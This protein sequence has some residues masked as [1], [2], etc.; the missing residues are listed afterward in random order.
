MKTAEAIF[1]NSKELDA[2]IILSEKNRLYYTG[3]HSTFGILLFLKNGETHFY[4]D[5]RYMEMAEQHFAGNAQVQLHLFGANASNYKTIYE[6]L[7]DNNVSKLGFEDSEMTVYDFNA[8]KL[9]FKD[10]KFV[11]CSESILEQ[12]KIKTEDEIELITK[13][14]SI[15][16]ASFK[17]VL[18]FIKP[19]ITEL[20]V[21]VEL[22]Y[23]MRKNGATGFAF[24]TIVASGVNGSKPHAHPTDKK[25]ALGDA[26]TM[27]FGA[28]YLG[29]CS[30][31]TRTVFV[32]KPQPQVK[33]I[34]EIVLKAQNHAI[35][36]L[37]C[38]MTGAEGHALAEEIISAN[39]YGQ[40]FTHGL[41]HSLG[42]DIHESPRLSPNFEGTL[43]P[44]VLMTVEPGIY[45]PN[46][47]GVRI[48]DLLV[49]KQ[50]R[51]IDLTTS[52]KNII[53]L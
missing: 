44:N 38:G 24:D 17:S 27:D 12:R 11:G 30:D 52:E 37:A 23:Q 53:I 50:D 34:Y 7:L 43:Q 47:G 26:V 49:I 40:Y 14:Q 18:K 5:A 48:E 39:G 8:F 46:V 21:A 2:I 22:E 33:E 32:G 15:T 6:F 45:V 25:I 36:N 9:K 4:T 41:G 42:L 10:M 29:Y 1:R 28:K 20:D 35:K 3:F 31:M 13:A 19:G 16:D 51:V